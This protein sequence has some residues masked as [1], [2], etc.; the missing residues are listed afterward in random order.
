MTQEINPDNIGLFKTE[1][2]IK[3]SVFIIVIATQGVLLFS[4]I[5]Q[6]I[7]D[8]KTLDVADKQIINFRLQN[9]ESRFQQAAILP[10]KPKLEIK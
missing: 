5:K 7:H 6:E 3:A 4:N 9:L 2:L 8:N 1:N 10:K